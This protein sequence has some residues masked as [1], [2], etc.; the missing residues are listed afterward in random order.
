MGQILRP[1]LDRR[2]VFELIP[3]LSVTFLG[4]PLVTDEWGFR[5]GHS[6]HH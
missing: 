6:R 5:M 1:S 4:S 2:I 3:D